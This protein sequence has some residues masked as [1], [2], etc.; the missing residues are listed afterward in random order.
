MVITRN[1]WPLDRSQVATANWPSVAQVVLAAPGRKGCPIVNVVDT[2]FQLPAAPMKTEN[3]DYAV[4]VRGRGEA[5]VD[6]SGLPITTL[7]TLV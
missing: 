4:F 3:V 1:R 7:P 5:V 6:G 2:G